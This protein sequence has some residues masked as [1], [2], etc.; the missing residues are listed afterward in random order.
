PA[1]AR[2]A[3][4]GGTS[5]GSSPRSGGWRTRPRKPGYRGATSIL[6]AAG[7]H[8]TR[9]RAGGRRHDALALHALDHAG[10]AI[11][12]DA[13]PPLE[14][15]ERRLAVLGHE[16]HGQVVH[17]VRE[18]LV[19]ALV[20]LVLVALEELHLVVRLLLALDEV[21]HP[22]DVGVGDERA[23]QALDARRAG[24]E[25]EQVPLAEQA[26]RAARVE[27]GAR[28]D[29]RGHLKGDAGR[30]VRLD[31]AGN[32]VDRRALRGEDQMDACGPRL[33]GE[34]RDRLLDLAPD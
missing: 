10:G 20:A 23:V 21:H 11:V 6:E 25:E 32:D 22:V 15:G 17:L 16:P 4:R 12:A 2:R 30:E 27:D 3:G 13:E 24:R 31:E 1:F 8:F 28:V 34:A 33:L 5:R 18:V 29:A 14:P 19:L 7:D 26:L 9:P